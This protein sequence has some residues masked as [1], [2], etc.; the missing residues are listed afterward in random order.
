MIIA[1]LTVEIWPS[2]WLARTVCDGTLCPATLDTIPIS[3]ITR[4]IKDESITVMQEEGR[5]KTE[6]LKTPQGKTA[7]SFQI[8]SKKN[9]SAGVTRTAGITRCD[10]LVLSFIFF[11]RM[12]G[13][14][15]GPTSLCHSWIFLDCLLVHEKFRGLRNTG[16]D[17]FRRSKITRDRR[18]DG[19]TD[20][21]TRPL[22]EMRS[23][24]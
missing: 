7:I 3:M 14:T 8:L 5:R 10:Y 11:R 21:R 12:D 22:I 20:G 2:L 4:L 17:V 13:Q 18:T 16:N 9:L 23:R 15:D 1:L 24:I 19:P 6:C